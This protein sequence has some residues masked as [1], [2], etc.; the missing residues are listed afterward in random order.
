MAV[1]FKQHHELGRYGRN[2]KGV[3]LC[4]WPIVRTGAKG[5]G[6]FRGGDR[7][8]MDQGVIPMRKLVWIPVAW[9]LLVNVLSA[10]AQASAPKTVYTNKP[11]FRIPYH[12]NADEMRELAAREIRLYVSSDMGVRWQSVQAVPPQ[13][14]KFNFQAPAEGEYWF[15]VR[16]LD[17]RN[18]LHPS[19][20]AVRPGLQVVV[21]T[22]APQLQLSLRQVVPGRAQLTWSAKDD[23][24]DASQFRMEYTQ[25]GNPNWQPI[26]VLPKA[27]GA[28][29]WNVPQGGVVAVRGTI[30]DLAGNS[31]HH[32]TR[33]QIAPGNGESSNVPD[34]RDPVAE[35]NP[36]KHLSENVRPNQI[37]GQSA[38]STSGTEEW[39]QTG[40]ANGFASLKSSNIPGF[41]PVSLPRQTGPVRIVNQR[42]FQIGY[43]IEEVGPSGISGV[44]L[45]ITQDNG[46]TWYR[47]GEDSDKRSPFLVN[48]PR[49]G[50]YG[51]NLLVRSGVGLSADPPQ[52]GER[53]SIVVQVDE[54]AP[55]VQLLPTEQGRGNALNKLLIR[56]TAHDENLAPQPI[57]LWHGNSTNGP[58]QPIALSLENTGSFIWTM[59]HGINS[60]IYFRIEAI[61]IAGNRQRIDTTEPMLIDLSKPTARIID[62]ESTADTMNTPFPN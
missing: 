58:W 16:T 44:E 30:S 5:Q 24:L 50:S 9:L 32:E 26:P 61:D 54:S 3:G 52:P 13:P 51:F 19:D 6:M 7:G 57:S 25:P 12:F 4:E 22:T 43:R 40:S 10:E 48:V 36:D 34:F 14:G 1:D 56:W 53:P 55:K 41:S 23:Y 35:G 2:G 37:P 8:V 15:C 17:G 59:P 45:F 11:R 49:E 47:Y 33:V 42:Q 46:A 18:Q 39:A 60:Q 28:T 29:E 38:D 31:G 21:D 20:D 27:S 62:I